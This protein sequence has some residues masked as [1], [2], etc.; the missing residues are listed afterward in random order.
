MVNS[1]KCAEMQNSSNVLSYYSGLINLATKQMT[2]NN[3]LASWLDQKNNAYATKES[4]QISKDV[5]QK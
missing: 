1:N 5:Q 4:D 3:G 2:S